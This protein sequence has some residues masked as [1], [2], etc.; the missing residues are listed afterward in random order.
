MSDSH[1]KTRLGSFTRV[2]GLLVVALASIWMCAPAHAAKPAR[3]AAARA[4]APAARAAAPAE[5]PESAQAV[6]P[7]NAAECD[8]GM[9]WREYS[10]PV[11]PAVSALFDAARTGDEAT[12]K[13]LI[14]TISDVQE[15]AVDDQPLLAA[16]LS[17]DPNLSAAR[18]AQR[19]IYWDM[20]KEE[21]RQVRA[22]HAATLAAKTRMLAL[23]LQHG[24]SVKD[25]TNLAR[26]PPLHLAVAFGTPEMVRLLL[27]YGANV[28][29]RDG[30][31]SQTAVE[32]A[33][34]HEIFI[35]MRYLPELVPSEQRSDMLL[36]MLAAGAKR[37]YALIDDYK[38]K[39]GIKDIPG[40][41]ADYLLWPALAEITR[42]SKVMEAMS[43][44][45]TL[46]VFEA[47]NVTLSP[48][49]HAARSGNLG[50]LQWLKARAPRRVSQRNEDGQII[51]TL[52]SW[53]VA[54]SWAAYPP[55]GDDAAHRQV[56]SILAD[57]IEPGMDW[58]QQNELNDR[59][60][61]PDIH[62]GPTSFPRG[63][64][65]L[66]HLAFTGR[67]EWVKRVVGLGAPVDGDPGTTPTPLYEA[68]LIGDVGMAS[69][70]LSL[71]ADPMAGPE[72]GFSPFFAALG[73]IGMRAS[74]PEDPLEVKRLE[75]ARFD[76]LQIM[77]AGMTQAQKIAL[78]QGK[79]SP[80]VLALSGADVADPRFVRSLLE[81]GIPAVR[82]GPEN[83]AAAMAIDDPSL[84]G[85]LIDRGASVR[86]D[87]ND[88]LIGSLLI[89]AL[90][91]NRPD[92]VPRLLRAGAN[93]NRADE[94]GK[95]AVAWAIVSG[96]VK[97]FDL[98]LAHGGKTRAA[99]PASSTHSLLDLAMAS[100]NQEMV[101][102]VA[103]NGDFP[104]SAACLKDNAL[105]K[106]VVLDSRD[107]FW[108]WL[109]AQGF[110]RTQAGVPACAGQ[111]PMVD[112]IIQDLLYEPDLIQAGWQGGRLTRRLRDLTVQAG[113]WSAA[114][115]SAL[116]LAV[117]AKGRDDL[118]LVLR[119]IGASEES[120]AP[121]SKPAPAPIKQTAAD[122]AL[123]KRLPGHYYLEGV[124]E[125]GSEIL[126]HKDGRFEYGLSYGAADEHA[127]GSWMVSGGRVRF[128]LGTSEV[129]ADRIPFKRTATPLDSA[130]LA[131]DAVSVRVVY[132]RTTVNRVSVTVVGC[133]EPVLDRG[134]TE[135]D[136]W[137]G[138]IPGGV[139]Q[140]ILRHPEINKGRGFIYQVPSEDAA[141]RQFDF[142]AQG[143]RPSENYDFD[144]GMGVKKGA[145]IWKRYGPTG[146]ITLRYVS[147]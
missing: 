27:N 17:P 58:N 116:L 134:W 83:L 132:G 57:L 51:G 143:F 43:K 66:H 122:K 100:G 145:L 2:Q 124:P 29:Q 59:T 19:K 39:E 142:E 129:P 34:D 11:T 45:G 5:L 138:Q 35:R 62:R 133:T 54:A 72:P 33:V 18:R 81:S 106:R 61:S 128:A 146:G 4:A 6:S 15:Y 95:S 105:L 3:P 65:L 121:M 25:V 135:D 8:C 89:Q 115:G 144:E 36:A 102:R 109:M 94:S 30:D 98:L 140:I 20:S 23:A 117:N 120:V 107:Q 82:V 91:L 80:L 68:V 46:P 26:H 127:E 12:F 123:Q 84:V 141:A 37:P 112:R 79:S 137:A 131:G 99:L 53:L 64:T 108:S 96:D 42:G 56:D 92:L 47:D 74:A 113:D 55:P 86:D 22:A 75:K 63:G 48:L 114:R 78:G 7:A 88:K 111:S 21:I 10:R 52:D 41:S 130:P 139:C 14:A 125:V 69:L 71:G 70:L 28:E 77:L 40:P 87:V 103:P 73:K 93:P 13:R 31:S 147:H 1:S 85:D 136:G 60:E 101:G 119:Q 16:L 67:Q 38:E 126:L 90:R 32:F 76:C 9:P 49:G 50:G 104:L 110:A 97:T 44:T 24:A 118:A